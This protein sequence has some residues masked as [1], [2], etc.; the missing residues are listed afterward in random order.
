MKI[1]A[2]C[3]F[4]PCISLSAMFSTI[5]HFY[6]I[7]PLISTVHFK[8]QWQ[9]KKPKFIL[10]T[11]YDGAISDC[12]SNTK[13]SVSHRG[14]AFSP[15]CYHVRQLWILGMGYVG[16][17]RKVPAGNIATCDEYCLKK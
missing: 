2:M 3:I 11:M 4:Q 13:L 10:Y 12:K 7:S 17:A 5:A 14:A 16:N 1:C 9:A 6:G 15:D 8:V